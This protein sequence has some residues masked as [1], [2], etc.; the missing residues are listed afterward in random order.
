[1]M[2]I[3]PFFITEG[4][5]VKALK[6]R[7]PRAQKVVYERYSA[8]MMAVCIRYVSNQTNAEEVMIDGFM[9]VYSK[10]DQFRE[11]GSFEGWLRR[12]M[13]TEALMFL[14]RTKVLQYEVSINELTT[15]PATEWPNDTIDSA[16]LL[17]LISQLPDGYRTVFNLYA[18]EGYNHE[19]IA[20]MLGI[21]VGTSKSQ[22]SRAR[23]LL[24][25][26]VRKLYQQDP[27]M[28]Y[29]KTAD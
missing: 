27:V 6:D 4:Q 3:I 22:L 29:G 14:R 26:K 24:Q 9:R 23:V 25:Q 7:E 1:M 28:N 5:L 18:I 15:E 11:E 10:I 2:R 19:E 21:S 16:S 12:I 20:A 8:R 13:V 17:Q